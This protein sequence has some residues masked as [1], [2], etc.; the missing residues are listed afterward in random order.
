VASGKLLHTLMTPTRQILSLIKAVFDSSFRFKV[1]AFSLRGSPSLFQRAMDLILSVLTWNSCLVY[2][3]DIIIF[4]RTA[5]AHIERLEEVFK[6]L[7]D[8]NLKI[9]SEKCQFLQQQVSFLGYKASSQGT[10]LDPEKTRVIMDLKRPTCIKELKISIG[11]F[12][13]FYDSLDIFTSQF[14]IIAEP[15][16]VLT[17]IGEKFKWTPKQE[18]AFQFLKRKLAQAPV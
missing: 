13:Y 18:E 5:T 9:Q 11:C 14:S 2:V 15:L 7:A 10:I 17:R 3:D 12:S 16:Y 4:S 6:R 1:L 8:H